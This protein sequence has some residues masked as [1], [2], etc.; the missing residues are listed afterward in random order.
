MQNVTVE[1]DGDT[2]ILRVNL[3]KSYGM[4]ESRKSK[5]IA[6]SNGPVSLRHYGLHDVVMGLNVWRKIRPVKPRGTRK[7]EA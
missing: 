1:V 7:P 6:T 4:T 5:G 2:L 3:S